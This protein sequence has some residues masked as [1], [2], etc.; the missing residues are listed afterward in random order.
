MNRMKIEFQTNLAPTLSKLG[1]ENKT[2]LIYLMWQYIIT[3]FFRDSILY[4]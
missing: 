4:K 2:T 1:K 3:S